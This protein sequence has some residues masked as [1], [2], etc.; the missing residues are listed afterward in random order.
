[1][2]SGGLKL[3]LREQLVPDL[4]DA[5]Y[6]YV[7]L[8]DTTSRPGYRRPATAPPTWT[9]VYGVVDGVDYALLRS[10]D[11]WL[12]APEVPVTVDEVMAAA[13]ADGFA[14]ADLVGKP[15]MRIG[16]K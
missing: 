7:V 3:A 11:L 2:C 10:P 4:W 9:A 13:K 14:P 8:C 5:G 15:G 12:A 1:M 16:G 6:W